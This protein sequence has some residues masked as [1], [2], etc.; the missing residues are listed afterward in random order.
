MIKNFKNFINE[1]VDHSLYQSNYDD[2]EKGLILA[3]GHLLYLGY[4]DL[5]YNINNIVSE[6]ETKEYFNEYY[7]EG[8]NDDDLRDWMSNNP[9][10]VG[11]GQA[12]FDKHRLNRMMNDIAIKTRTLDPFMIYRYEDQDYTNG[13]NSYT[14]DPELD[15]S[16]QGKIPKKSYLIPAGY[17][18]I[19]ADGIGDRDEVIINL[20]SVEKR[21][22]IR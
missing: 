20:S 19:F 10:T 17:P 13:W 7:R 9:P 14:T 4:H 16:N 3:W 5:P 11:N 8:E 22:L 12:I 18:V 21:K 1:S 6:D 2:W 15:Y